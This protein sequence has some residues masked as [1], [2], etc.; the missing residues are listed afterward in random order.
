MRREAVGEAIREARLAAGM[1]QEQ[2]AQTSRVSR[3]AIARLELGEASTQIDRL[4][5]IAAALG[6]EPDQIL[7]AAQRIA[8]SSRHDRP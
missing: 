3:S 1:T 8:R 2:L 4:W 6:T 7:A 5:D